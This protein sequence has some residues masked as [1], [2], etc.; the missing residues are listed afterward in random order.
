MKE[1]ADAS[2]LY[3]WWGWKLIANEVSRAELAKN[4]EYI[5]DGQMSNENDKF[6]MG[7]WV[8]KNLRWFLALLCGWFQCEGSKIYIDGMLMLV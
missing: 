3:K 4:F 2:I 5:L 1:K 6:E 7:S 8:K